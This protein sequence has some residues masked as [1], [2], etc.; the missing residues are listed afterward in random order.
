MRMFGSKIIAVSGLVKPSELGKY[1]IRTTRSKDGF[2][3]IGGGGLQSL[4]KIP[5]DIQL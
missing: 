3:C 2:V 4:P 1:F 5:L